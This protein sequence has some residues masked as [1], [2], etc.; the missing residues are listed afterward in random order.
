VNA[1]KLVLAQHVGENAHLELNVA[2]IVLAQNVETNAGPEFN[3]A[4]MEFA[5]NVIAMSADPCME[6]KAK[7]LVAT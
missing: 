4:N 1:A 2:T 3:A 5:Q 7:A 6:V